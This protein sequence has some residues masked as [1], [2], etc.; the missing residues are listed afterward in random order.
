MVTGCGQYTFILP[1]TRE[2]PRR[3]TTHPFGW[4]CRFTLDQTVGGAPAVPGGASS[5]VSQCLDSVERAR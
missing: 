4:C 5:D 1:A 2:V 3:M